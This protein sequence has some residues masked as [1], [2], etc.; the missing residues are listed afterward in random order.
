MINETISMIEG[1]N[2][3]RL[4][5]MSD[6]MKISLLGSADFFGLNYYTS[7]LVS[8]TTTKKRMSWENDVGVD[9]MN[10]TVWTEDHFVDYF[11]VPEGL[12]YVLVWIKDNYNNP[13]VFITENGWGDDRRLNDDHRIDYLKTHLIAISDAINKDK[14]NVIG[15]TVYSLIDSFEWFYGYTVG[16]GLYSVNVS[17][18]TLDR[19]A[20]K[21]VGF[22]KD[23]IKK[24]SV[25]SNSIKSGPFI[26]LFISAFII[27]KLIN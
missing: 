5:T 6:E 16:F 10:Y 20:K 7:R 2:I 3:S 1:R 13:P 23:V 12:Q 8:E 4:P 11:S 22:M 9:F 19:I 26:G 17:S 15:Y 27:H 24:N 25:T 18:P 14:C 21:S